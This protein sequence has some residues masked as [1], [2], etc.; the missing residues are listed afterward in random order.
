ME[1]SNNYSTIGFTGKVP[2][3]NWKTANGKNFATELKEYIPIEQI[4][5]KLAPSL[6]HFKTIEAKLPNIT[7]YQRASNGEL[8]RLAVE[9]GDVN[10]E[11][12]AKKLVGWL[13]K[14]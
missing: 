1:L 12:I 3:K 14:S 10:H 4:K 2:V 11:A 8:S 9:L 6:E 7:C 5:D 13:P